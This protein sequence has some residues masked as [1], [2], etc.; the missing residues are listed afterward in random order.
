MT[1]GWSGPRP[2]R[3]PAQ[4]DVGLAGTVMRFLPPVAGLAE[5]AVSFDGDPLRPQ[6]AGG[7]AV[8]AR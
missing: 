1:S 2:L 4:I 8:A 6:A 5:G 3:G 7:A